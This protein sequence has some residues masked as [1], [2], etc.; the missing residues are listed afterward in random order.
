MC[1]W[2]DGRPGIGTETGVDGRP[3]TG[4]GQSTQGAEHKR[5]YGYSRDVTL[6]VKGDGFHVIFSYSEHGSGFPCV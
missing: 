2:V 4:E 1:G 5:H 3:G 6:G